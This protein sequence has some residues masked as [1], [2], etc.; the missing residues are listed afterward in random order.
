[1]SNLNLNDDLSELEALVKER[2]T[3]VLETE[4]V[5]SEVPSEPADFSE[6]LFLALG[7]LGCSREDVEQARAKYNKIYVYPWSENDIF[8]YRVLTRREWTLLKSA[9]KTEDEL[10]ALIMKRATVFPKVT[11]D[12]LDSLPAGIQEV[13]PQIVLRTCAF[14]GLDEAMA[15]VKEL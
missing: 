13:Y 5:E 7:K 8:V 6:E 1:M 3:E 2:A 10:S 9:A 12:L 4:V 11:E 15:L 14:I